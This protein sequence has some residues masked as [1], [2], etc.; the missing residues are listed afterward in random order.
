MTS[1][2]SGAQF[3]EAAALKTLQRDA[4]S[5]AKH[6]DSF[7]KAK[8]GDPKALG[9]LEKAL[10]ALLATAE[11]V[12]AIDELRNRATSILASGRAGRAEAIRRFEADFIRA[13]REAGEHVRES[14]DS[15]WRV[16]QFELDIQRER[17]QA[18]VL[19]NKEVV[20]P[21]AP[22]AGAGD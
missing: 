2:S 3:D 7:A 13:R 8:A 19:Y 22:I 9:E 15:A 14:G 11:L 10:A 5:I 1:E 12:A 16:G 18:R 20:A 6:L 17:A 4:R 21:W